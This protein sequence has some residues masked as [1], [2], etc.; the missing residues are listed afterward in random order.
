[1]DSVE[2]AEIVVFER[3]TVFSAC[4]SNEKHE[5]NMEKRMSF[6]MYVCE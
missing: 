6:F 5:S 4:V 3:D 1:L 2:E